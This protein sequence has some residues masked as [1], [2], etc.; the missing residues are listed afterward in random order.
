MA[1]I[2]SY[3]FTNVD[4]DDE[5][6]DLKFKFGQKISNSINK[7]YSRTPLFSYDYVD[8]NET[9]YN[10]SQDCFDNTDA[11]KYFEK[12]KEFSKLAIDDIIDES[13]YK[14]HFHIYST[15]KHK[16]RELLNKIHKKQLRD[17]QLPP[18]GQF[19]LYTNEN[20]SRET[21][22]KSPRIYFMVGDYGIFYILFYDPY[23]EINQQ[24]K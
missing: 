5:F 4:Y 15:P 9:A 11:K 14:K 10:F 17:E 21:K 1:S 12:V 8:L 6:Q 13:S 20:A 16:Q 2:N 19:A 3:K 18:I 22:I 23:H 24:K 7:H